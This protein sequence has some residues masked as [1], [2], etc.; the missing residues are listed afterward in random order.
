MRSIAFKQSHFN[1]PPRFCILEPCWYSHL[2]TLEVDHGIEVDSTRVLGLRLWLKLLRWV[3][4]VGVFQYRSRCTVLVTVHCVPVTPPRTVS[5]RPPLRAR[6]ILVSRA[7]SAASTSIDSPLLK[8]L[9]HG[10]I[11]LFDLCPPTS[12]Q[13]PRCRSVD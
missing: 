1:K 10:R 9:I 3:L 5:S 13:K 12:Y 4:G 7:H 6:E 8:H 2:Y 11:L